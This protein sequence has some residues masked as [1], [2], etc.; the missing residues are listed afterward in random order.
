MFFQFNL[1]KNHTSLKFYYQ[2]TRSVLNIF[3]RMQLAAQREFLLR[4]NH[5]WIL[6]NIAVFKNAADSSGNFK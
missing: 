2:E 5:F 6:R 4:K 3:L 1:T